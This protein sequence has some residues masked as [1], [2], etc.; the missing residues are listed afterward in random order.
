M[1]VH[2]S[3]TFRA[4]ATW[5]VEH[6][7]RQA[8]TSD[9]GAPWPL[10]LDAERYA[11]NAPYSSGKNTAAEGG[12]RVP[13]IAWWPD[14]I[15]AGSDCK[16]LAS[17]IDFLPTF[18]SLAGKP[19]QAA[20]DRPIDGLNLGG[21]FGK[22]IPD[23]SPRDTF[24]YYHDNTDGGSPQP[25]RLVAVRQERWKCYRH[26]QRFRSANGKTVLEIP[27]G[28]LFNLNTDPAET[29]DGSANHRNIV[30]QLHALSDLYAEKFG[31]PVGPQGSEIRRAGFVAKPKPLNAAWKR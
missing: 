1:G 28:A 4:K 23:A 22:D 30:S 16:L 15:I 6:P 12:F 21:M 17:T 3:F 14:T 10:K 8:R 5:S 19:Y 11:S 9:N 18:A 26:P 2:R 24:V 27:A 7:A 25:R 20:K 13:M 31:D 29:T